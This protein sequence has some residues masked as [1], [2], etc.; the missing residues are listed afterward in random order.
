MTTPVASMIAVLAACFALAGDT[1]P[2]AREPKGVTL[3]VSKSGDNTDGR[4]WKTAFHTIQ[5]AL[6]AVP[7]DRGGHRLVVRPDTY[8]EANLYPARKGAKGAYNE[9][10]GDVDGSLGSGAT[11]WV[12]VDSSDPAKGFK[13][14]D[15]WGPIRAYQKAWSSEHKGETFSSVAWDRWVLRGLYV[16]GGDGGVFWDL[17]GK[18]EPFTIVVEDCVGIG[19]AFGGGVANH[20]AR[21]DEPCVFRRCYLCCLDWWGDAGAAYVR[22]SHASIPSTPDATFED[23]TLVSPDN[24]L[25]VGYP[26]F[27][28]HTRVKFTKCRLIVLNFSQPAGTPSRGI[29]HTPL[30]GK[31][32]HVDLEDCQMMGYKVFSTEGKNP[33]GY[34]VKGKVQAYVQFQQPVP[35]GMERLG[36]WPVELF[37]R[38]APPGAPARKDPP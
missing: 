5:G 27:P 15:W 13:S 16:T 21:P 23:C 10:V 36:Q 37:G 4:S 17:V 25:E 20:E 6:S 29:I 12:I 11:G 34:T 7:D 24:A 18:V 31:Q 19:R 1:T 22:C 8:V 9:L 32:L 35:A 38:I 14:Y 26:K 33:I 2:T 3:Y 30:D 28:G